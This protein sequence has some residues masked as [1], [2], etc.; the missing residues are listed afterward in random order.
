MRKDRKTFITFNLNAEHYQNQFASEKKDV[1]YTI[2]KTVA[3][4]SY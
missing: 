2:T 3:E 1:M 4:L